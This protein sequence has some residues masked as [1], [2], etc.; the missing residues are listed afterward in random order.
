MTAGLTTPPRL[1]VKGIVMPIDQRPAI[2]R[3]ETLIAF[4][5]FQST[6]VTR[7]SG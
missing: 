2:V 6:E 1:A 5:P 3:A 4:E 7:G